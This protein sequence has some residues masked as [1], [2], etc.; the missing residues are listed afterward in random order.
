MKVALQEGVFV[1]GIYTLI[2]RLVAFKE[3]VLYQIRLNAH[4]F[5][6]VTTRFATYF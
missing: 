1:M 4:S 5:N 3:E 6:L 2:Q